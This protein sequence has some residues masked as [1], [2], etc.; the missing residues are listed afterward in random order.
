MKN[1]SQSQNIDHSLYKINI[2]DHEQIHYLLITAPPENTAMY[3]F[4]AAWLY[5]CYHAEKCFLLKT[6]I[7]K[8]KV[9][10]AFY[11]KSATHAFHLT[12]SLYYYNECKHFPATLSITIPFMGSI[13]WHMGLRNPMGMIGQSI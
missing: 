12:N 6:W 8:T 10:I 3:C 5:H 4:C 9:L 7:R 2:A 13:G 1:S 11:S